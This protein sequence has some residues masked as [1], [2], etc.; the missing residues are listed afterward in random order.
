MIEAMNSGARLNHIAVAVTD[1][2]AALSFYRDALGLQLDHVEDVQE[3]KSKVAFLPLGNSEIE[4]VQ[5]TSDDTGVA[6]WLARHGAGM[7]HLAIQV[8]NLDATLQRLKQHN[9]ELISPEPK[10]KS[11][12][13]RYAFV[14][15]KSAFGVLVELYEV[16]SK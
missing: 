6:K 7:H 4:L 16:R 11:N 2:E 3:E 9:I 10:Q 13:T 8:E 5:P 14:H 15:P 12:G 1:L